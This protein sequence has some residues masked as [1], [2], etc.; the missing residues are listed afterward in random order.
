MPPLW[1]RAK[2]IAPQ[3]EDFHPDTQDTIESQGDCFTMDALL[4]TLCRG[5]GYH[6]DYL[7]VVPDRI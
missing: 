6:A 7:A 1:H 4:P 3:R 2:P 5:P